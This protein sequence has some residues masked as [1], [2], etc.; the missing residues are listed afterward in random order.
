M[1]MAVLDAHGRQIAPHMTRPNM[2]G[3]I[4]LMA[5]MWLI[6]LADHKGLWRIGRSVVI[7]KS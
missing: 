3:R 7:L 1:S 5:H 4:G 6:C 2:R